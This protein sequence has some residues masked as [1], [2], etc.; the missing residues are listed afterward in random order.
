MG[1]RI[2][3]IVPL[4]NAESTLRAAAAS[5]L[6]QDVDGLELIL[7]D[8][9]STDGTAA[10]CH[11]ISRQDARV[12]VIS[13]KNAG[14]CA[15]RNR[16]LSAA[17][18][19]YV[20]FCDD[21]DVLLPGALPLLLHTAESMQCDVVRADY[22][23]LR[24]QTD[25]TFQE[26]PHDAG[27][28]CDLQKDGYAA[29]LQN[30]GPQFV[31]NALYRR[32][33]LQNLWFDERCRY[34]LEDFIFNMQVYMRTARAVYLP[35]AVYRHFERGQSTSLCQSAKAIRGRIQSLPI[36]MEAEHAALQKRGT[37]QEKK[38]LWVLRRAEAVT[39]LMHQLRDARAPAALRRY[40]WTSL[41]EALA[42]YPESP[43][44][45][46]YGAGQNKKKA[47]ALLLYQL[48]IPSVYDLLSQKQNKE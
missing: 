28:V 26:L 34:G 30:S 4:F 37:E 32:E 9:G 12:R 20:G 27:V 45:F 22:E 47:A 11:E 48:H 40:A 7:V 43:L 24:E 33:L 25:G 15:A 36:W 38:T 39:F 23:L 19:T 16:G 18:G 1:T 8:D 41:R 42:P 5:I 29:F 44:D 3:L 2:S 14:I 13:Q 31:W 6:A 10:V 21:D 46:L 17:T 35:Q